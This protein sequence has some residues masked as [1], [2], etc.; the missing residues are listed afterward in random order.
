MELEV[1]MKMKMGSPNDHPMRV[2]LWRWGVVRWFGGRRGTVRISVR[3]FGSRVTCGYRSGGVR[4]GLPHLTVIRLRGTVRT[5][6]SNV[7]SVV[8]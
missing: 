3:W 7:V 8:I 5:A 6:A 1:E 2:V 4:T